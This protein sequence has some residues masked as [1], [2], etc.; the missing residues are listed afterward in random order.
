MAAVCLFVVVISQKNFILDEL[1][2]ILLISTFEH[3]PI[4]LASS[5]IK[6]YPKDGMYG[7]YIQLL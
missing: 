2:T 3:L 5:K 6:F 4:T 7:Q 1:F